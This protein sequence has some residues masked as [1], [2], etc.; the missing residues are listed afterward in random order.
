VIGQSALVSMEISELTATRSFA[1]GVLVV[2]DAESHDIPPLEPLKTIAATDSTVVIRVRH[3]QDVTDIDDSEFLVNVRVAADSGHG[4]GVEATVAVP[5]G[6]LSV[7]DANA[8]DIVNLRPGRWRLRIEV[9][10][11]DVPE[12]VAVWLSPEAP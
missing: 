9:E 10:P 2:G 3:A 7:G 4:E 12:R 5:S 6:R 1:W 11:D 8:A